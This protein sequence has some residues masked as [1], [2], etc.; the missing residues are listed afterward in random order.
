M[1]RR[2]RLFATSIGP[3]PGDGRADSTVHNPIG[4]FLVVV[5]WIRLFA[6]PI[7]PESWCWA[8]PDPIEKEPLANRTHVR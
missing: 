3:I 8:Q 7:G 1:V 2:I 6:T 4:P 5:G